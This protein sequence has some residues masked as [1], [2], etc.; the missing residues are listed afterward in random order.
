MQDYLYLTQ[1]LFSLNIHSF[2]LM[3]NHFHLIV[4]APENNLGNAMNYFMRETSK[5][6]NRMSQRINQT[7][8]ARY[9]RSL[10]NGIFYYQNAY[11]YVYR[12][13]VRAGLVR[14]AEDYPYSTLHGLCGKGHQHIP[15][16][17]DT[18]LFNPNFDHKSLEWINTPPED[19]IESEVRKALRKPIF[20]IKRY[21][22]QKKEPGT[23]S[24]TQWEGRGIDCLKL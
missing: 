19:Q 10:I 6:M 15:L 24:G 18:L 14:R 20:E 4:T 3:P 5:E 17:E 22:V 8:G 12:N 11:K 16:V 2:V 7:F 13:P 23:F 21:P 9:H 1:K